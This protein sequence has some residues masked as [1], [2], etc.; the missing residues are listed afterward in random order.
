M[1][2]RIDFSPFVKTDLKEIKDWYQ[3]I[4][5]TLVDRFFKEFENETQLLSQNPLSKEVK[6][7]DC[8]ISYLKNFP[9]GIH[10]K[11]FDSDNSI[12]IIGIYHVSRNP[13]IWKSRL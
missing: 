4:N 5:K 6:Y 7:K 13:E 12:L 3:K 2:N 1:K 11:Y 9:F 8:R 10:Y